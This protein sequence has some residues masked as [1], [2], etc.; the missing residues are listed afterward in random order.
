MKAVIEIKNVSKNYGDYQA[1]NDISFE[2]FDNEF[3]TILGPS[4]C[5]KTTLLRMI[6]GFEL[7][8]SGTISLQ[9]ENIQG[10]PAHKRRVNTVFQNYALFPHMNLAENISFGLEMLGWG[11]E[12]RAERVNEMLK[13]VHMEQFAKRKPVQLSGGQ[14]Q[15][16][17]LARALAPKPEVLLLDEPL[18]ALDHKLRQTMRDELQAL[19]RETGITFIFVTHDQEEALAMSDRI[20]VLAHGEIQQLSDPVEIYEHPTNRFVAD[21]IGE[22]NFLPVTVKSSSDE[23]LLVETSLGIDVRLPPNRF[24]EG[25][26][27]TMS[28]RPEKISINSEALD[29]NLAGVVTHRRYMGGY[30]HYTVRLENDTEL[31]VS[32]RNKI[33]DDISFPLNETVRLSFA[34]KSARVLG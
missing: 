33:S 29:V 4:G 25:E 32:K 16:V 9:G 22:T 24:A 18:S 21:F 23:A 12:E 5:G 34:A 19:Q 2:I 15:R 3:F 11:A 7:P 28:I 1:I 30:T 27:A 13:L 20:C 8:T 31:R 26:T 14:Q 6:A 10:L 17:A